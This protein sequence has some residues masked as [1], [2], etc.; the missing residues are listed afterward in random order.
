MMIEEWMAW[1][2]KAYQISSDSKS[3]IV[4]WGVLPLGIA[5]LGL[6]RIVR[7]MFDQAF[8]RRFGL[9]GRIKCFCPSY[10]SQLFVLPEVNHAFIK[11]RGP[12]WRAQV[13][14]H[15]KK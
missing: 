3:G 9:H 4:V 11:C 8:R 10:V 14:F 7:G 6:Y 2:T 1:I 15:S 13:C 12:R 5:F